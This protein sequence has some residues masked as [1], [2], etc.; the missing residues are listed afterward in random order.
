M[1]LTSFMFASNNIFGSGYVDYAKASSNGLV[2]KYLQQYEKKIKESEN[3]NLASILS[4]LQ[5]NA[6]AEEVNNFL[7]T[8]DASKNKIKGYPETLANDDDFKI[9]FLY[10]FSAI[11]FHVASLMKSKNVVI[12]KYLLFSGTGSKVLNIIASKDDTLSKLTTAIFEKVYNQS[13]EKG[14]ITVKRNKDIPKELTCKGGLMASE[15]DLNIDTQE[16]KTIYSPLVK[17]KITFGELDENIFNL[18]LTEVHSFN[19]MFITLAKDLKFVDLFGASKE[20]I[21]EFEN[22]INENLTDYL[23]NGISFHKALDN[24]RDTDELKETMFFYPITGAL[25]NLISK[26]SILNPIAE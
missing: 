17:N 16:L 4:S 25:Q 20:S 14:T 6:K 13:I 12:P 5:L 23:N 3:S 9:G 18:V 2:N 19:N 11:V 22:V 26:L 8:I 10:Y 1:C 7:L 15:V 24:A 21:D